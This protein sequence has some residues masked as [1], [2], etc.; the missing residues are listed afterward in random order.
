MNPKEY[1]PSCYVDWWEFGT[2]QTHLDAP[3]FLLYR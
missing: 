2:E 3:T 1:T